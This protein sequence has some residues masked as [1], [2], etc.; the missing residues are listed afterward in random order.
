MNAGWRLPGRW[1]NACLTG[2]AS[3]S[4]MQNKGIRRVNHSTVGL[5]PG[6]FFTPRFSARAGLTHRRSYGGLDFPAALFDANGALIEDVL[7]HH[8]TI[9]NISY[10]ELH[11]GVSVK[12]NDR[13]TLFAS[14]GRT[15]RGENANLIKCAVSIGISRNF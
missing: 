10:T 3:Y 12:L 14:G 13:Y 1:Q 2:N 4:Y 8:D 7:F 15:L 9:R 6:S 11:V 5:D